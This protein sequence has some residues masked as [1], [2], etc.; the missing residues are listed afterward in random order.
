MSKGRQKNQNYN[1]RRHEQTRADKTKE[2]KERLEKRKSSRACLL[3]SMLLQDSVGVLLSR[4][5]VFVVLAAV[6]LKVFTTLYIHIYILST[7]EQRT[8]PVEFR[9]RIASSCEIAIALLP[10]L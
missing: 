3:F 4:D 6:V 2:E 8:H 9:H 5:S 1:R 10:Q 7:V